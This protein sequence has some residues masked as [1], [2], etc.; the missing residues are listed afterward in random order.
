MVFRFCGVVVLSVRGRLPFRGLRGS[1]GFGVLWFSGVVSPSPAGFGG[2]REQRGCCGFSVLWFCGVL[3]LWFSGVSVI[4]A[5][6]PPLSLSAEADAKE[7]G[8]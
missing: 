5:W 8:D 2:R 4:C 6:A 7:L 3:V 1:E